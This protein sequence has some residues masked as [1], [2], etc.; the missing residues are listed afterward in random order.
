[1]ADGFL[2]RHG[3]KTVINVSG[4]MTA[5]GA[6]RAGPSVANT[7]AEVL[8]HFVRM[9]ELQAAASR[10]ISLI[11]GA[12]AGCITACAASGVVAAVAGCMTGSD[13]SKIEQLPDTTGMKNEC[14]LQ[15]GH[16]VDFGAGVEQMI[17]LSGATC[18]EVGSINACGAYQVEGAV[19][20]RT[21]AAVYVVSHHTVQSGLV[22]LAHF[23]EAAHCHGVPVVVDAASEYDLTGFLAAGA[24][25]VVWSGHKFLGGPTSGIVAG[26]EELVRA[27]YLQE[28]GISRCM[29]VGKESVA[30]AMTALEDWQERNHAAVR[31]AEDA[32]IAAAEQALAGLAGLATA[33]EEDPTGNPITRLRVTVDPKA[34]GMSAFELSRMLAAGDPAI[35]VRDHHVDRGYF[36]L[37]PCNVT[38][39]EMTTVC[40][41]IAE[42]LLRPTAV[43]TPTDNLADLRA[44]ALRSWPQ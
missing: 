2:N 19:T 21:A 8:P 22:S 3:V 20:D 36:L 42:C 38:D 35:Q 26:T 11:T 15:R 7:M 40:T 23:V 25:I 6:S 32:R 17:R 41:R 39:D 5:L 27:T 37:D 10:L 29:K 30:G 44:G 33:R 4:T 9:S 16:A 34:T 43:T 28:H 14:I 12:Q 1:M 24:D 18:V 31:A 13:L